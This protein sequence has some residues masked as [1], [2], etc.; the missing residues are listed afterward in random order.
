VFKCLVWSNRASDPVTL[1]KS[2]KILCSAPDPRS[3][4][5]PTPWGF[6]LVGGSQ[7]ASWFANYAAILRLCHTAWPWMM[8]DVNV[9]D[10]EESMSMEEWRRRRRS[11]DRRH[12]V[13]VLF[14]ILQLTIGTATVLLS[15]CFIGIAVANVVPSARQ[16]QEGG[17]QVGGMGFAVGGGGDQIPQP[18]PSSSCRLHGQGE[19]YGEPSE[20]ATVDPGTYDEGLAQNKCNSTKSGEEEAGSRGGKGDEEVEKKPVRRRWKSITC[21]RESVSYP[22]LCAPSLSPSPPHTPF[23]TL[24]PVFIQFISPSLI[25]SAAPLPQTRLANKR[26]P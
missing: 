25:F 8:S 5:F 21:S 18:Q 2:R 3:P 24:T 11:T 15:S 4:D 16:G 19:A 20:G 9:N 17:C 23:M 10:P 1:V 26:Y 13:S 6:G 12:R 22:T 14:C 7:K